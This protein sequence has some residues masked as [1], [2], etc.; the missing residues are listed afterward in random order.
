MDVQSRRLCTPMNSMNERWPVGEIEQESIARPCITVI[1]TI[2]SPELW[3]Y[4]S[5]VKTGNDMALPTGCATRCRS[6]AKCLESILHRIDVFFDERH[7]HA[8]S[9]RA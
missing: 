1:N 8:H 5:R 4:A 6:R 9:Q 2:T 3:A 7:C